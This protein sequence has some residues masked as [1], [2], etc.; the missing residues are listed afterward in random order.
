MGA[1]ELKGQVVMTPPHLNDL[2]LVPA[3]SHRQ[4]AQDLE[5][6]AMQLL[7]EVEGGAAELLWIELLACMRAGQAGGG[8]R[9]EGVEVKS[10]DRQV[11]Q[12]H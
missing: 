6:H 9:T 10:A 2:V 3:Q 8:V 5:G 12:E 1:G 4:Q 7:L 11:R